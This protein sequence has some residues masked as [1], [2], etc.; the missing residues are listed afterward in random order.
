[1]TPVVCRRGEAI[2]EEGVTEAWWRVLEMQLPAT[3]LLLRASAGGDNGQRERD[4]VT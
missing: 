4:R 3:P 1:M 2:Q